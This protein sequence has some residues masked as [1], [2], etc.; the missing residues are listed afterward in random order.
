MRI[1]AAAILL[2]GC[3]AQ[4]PQR[5][6]VTQQVKVPVPIECVPDGVGG[7][8]I[9]SDTDAAIIAAPDDAALIYLF[10]TGRVERDLRLAII[11][12]VVEG[13]R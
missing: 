4:E 6:V 2:A 13:C 10:W 1:A 8:P 7:P 12:T 3:A 5:I 11:E 9:Y